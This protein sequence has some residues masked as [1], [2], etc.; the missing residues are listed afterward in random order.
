M[1]QLVGWSSENGGYPVTMT[2]AYMGGDHV[3]V[4]LFTMSDES[5]GSLAYQQKMETVFAVTQRELVTVNA[6]SRAERRP[7]RLFETAPPAPAREPRRLFDREVRGDWV[8]ADF[9]RPSNVRL[10]LGVT[11]QAIPPLRLRAARSRLRRLAD[12]A[13]AEYDTALSDRCLIV[14]TESDSP[15]PD[16]SGVE[17][18]VQEGEDES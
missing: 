13:R 5:I 3:Q 16:W 10:F 17:A 7:Q 2:W 18:A 11:D 14:V 1:A 12:R 15:E 8:T 4:D 6:V 9:A